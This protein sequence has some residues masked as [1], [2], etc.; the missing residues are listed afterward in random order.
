MA[1]PTLNTHTLTRYGHSKWDY[2]FLSSACP[3]WIE[4]TA[5]FNHFGHIILNTQNIS[6]LLAILS[7]KHQYICVEHIA[8]SINILDSCKP[9]VIHQSPS[10]SG[11]K[12]QVRAQ[13]TLSCMLDWQPLLYLKTMAAVKECYSV[14]GCV[15][16]H[17]CVYGY[18]HVFEPVHSY[19]AYIQRRNFMLKI[20]HVENFWC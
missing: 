20:I 2:S 16:V 8:N 10:S 9:V 13:H 11:Y 4:S 18:V 15:C 6:K 12:T 1:S 3:F 14:H 7:N 17:V 5:P 19:I